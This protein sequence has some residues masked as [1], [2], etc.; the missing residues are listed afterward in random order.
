MTEALPPIVG[1]IVIHATIERVWEI[2]TTPARI[3][4][5][6]GCLRFR[7]E[8]G[9]TFYMQPD[10]AKRA[11]D[12]I[13]GAT[14]CTIVT[15]DPP[16]TVAFTWFVPGT[17]ETLVTM[18]LAAAAGGTMVRLTH[19]GWENFPADAVRPFHQQLTS[20]WSSGVLPGLKRL[21]ESP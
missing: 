12:D 5:W 1:E 15:L 16:K 10:P 6:L 20:G 14:H 7:P 9:V 3:A 11:A 19:S 4:E 8:V 2:L 21:S 18:T 17:P 13:A